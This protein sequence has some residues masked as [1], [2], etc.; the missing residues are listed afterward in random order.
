MI[1][2]HLYQHIHP[3]VVRRLLNLWPDAKIINAGHYDAEN[4]DIIKQYWGQDDLVLVEQHK[5]LHGAVFPDFENCSRAYCLNP[6]ELMLHGNWARQSIGCVRWRK[7]LQQRVTVEDIEAKHD[8]LANSSLK[9]YEDVIC[10]AGGGI[11]WQHTEFAILWAA[12]AKG[13]RVHEHW[14]GVLHNKLYNGTEECGKYTELPSFVRNE[15]KHSADDDHTFHWTCHGLCPEQGMSE[16]YGGECL[17]HRHQ[18][19]GSVEWFSEYMDKMRA[20]TNA[21]LE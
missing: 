18:P 9:G 15:H 14:P 8:W 2:L 17:K 10:E 12:K 5:I 1:V 13:Y 6:H 3:P 11:C 21:I 19:D 16:C 7:E 20:L 4:W